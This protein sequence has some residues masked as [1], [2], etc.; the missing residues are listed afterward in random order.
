LECSGR[1]L[2][3]GVGILRGYADSDNVAFGARLAL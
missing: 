3:T 1:W 2:E